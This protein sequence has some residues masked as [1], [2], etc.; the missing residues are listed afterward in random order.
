MPL[1]V[2]DIREIAPL[3]PEGL[4]LGLRNYW[5]PVLQSEELPTDRA[6]GF[7]V[8]GE[9]LAAWR[10]AAGKPCVVRDR[11]PHRSVK[12]SAGRVLAGELQC[13]LHGLRFDGTGKCTLIPWE[14]EQTREGQRPAVQA[15]S[16]AELGGYVW[17]YLGD[18]NAMP[19]PPL[20]KEVPEELTKPDEFIWFRMPTEVWKANWL[21]TVD[22]SDGFHAVVLHSDSQAVANKTWTKGAVERPDV[23]LVDRRVRIVKTSHGIRGVAT[24]K[25]GNALH[26]GHFTKDVRGDRFALPCLTTNPI[27][28]APGATPYTARL[29]QFPIDAERTQIVRYAAWRAKTAAERENATR[30]FNELTHPRFKQV[31]AEDAAIAEAQGDLV[32]ARSQEYLLTPDVDVVKVRRLIRDA[33]VSQQTEAKRIAVRDGAMDYPF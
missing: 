8:L 29:W 2:N 21:L 30:V 6:V 16:A 20:E 10:D 25:A 12:L 5:Y 24:D 33:Y 17:A 27:V 23:P 31:S 19:P 3:I 18:A 13:I 4:P 14:N 32:T 28:P 7:T 26:H 22:G 15:Y 9:A 11:C 1:G